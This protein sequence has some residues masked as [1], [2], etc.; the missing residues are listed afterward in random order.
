MWYLDG[1]LL[2]NL[3]TNSLAI[4]FELRHIGNR[5]LLYVAYYRGRR[6]T[7]A[8]LLLSILP[9]QGEHASKADLMSVFA[10]ACTTLSRSPKNRW[11]RVAGMRSPRAYFTATV[12]QNNQSVLI[13]GGTANGVTPLASVEVY[14][15]TSG[16]SNAYNMLSA[17]MK[18]TATYL[19][20][21]DKVLVAGGLS[22]MGVTLSQSV[23]LTQSG[24]QSSSSMGISR[25]SHQAATLYDRNVLFVPGRVTNNTDHRVEIF[26]LTTK[27]FETISNGWQI[28]FNLEGHS[29][30]SDDNASV[31]LIFGGY[32][33]TAYP[34]VAFFY[35]RAGVV[36]L[37]VLVENEDEEEISVISHRAG[38][39]IT[40]IPSL[41]AFLLTGGHNH[42]HALSSCYLI[43]PGNG[44]IIRVGSMSVQR[45]WHA[46]V[47]MS[48]GSVLVIGGAVE[49]VDGMPMTPT[50]SVERFNLDTLRFVT[51][52][53]IAVARYGHIA[54]SDYDDEIVL[55]GGIGC[56]SMILAITEYLMYQDG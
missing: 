26:N 15:L 7:L 2:S 25:Y 51:V 32:N 14:N 39:Q 36:Q 47:R 17:R 28:L 6:V 45:T 46:A 44:S 19:E 48:N 9:N 16:C 27:T 12:L 11:L 52:G 21:L 49:P 37:N 23:L 40:Y 3:P 8:S 54:V 55:F 22:T 35:S 53:R 30:T 31:T 38:H 42:T 13:V 56:D 50:A 43:F 24:E 4:I 20:T 5:T 33:G 29:V 1:D 10:S 18:H 41:R 34:G